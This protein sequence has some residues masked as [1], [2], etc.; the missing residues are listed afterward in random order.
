MLV[1]DV[2]AELR[3]CPELVAADPALSPQL[4]RPP[5]GYLVPVL[6]AD[7]IQERLFGETHE[8]HSVVPRTE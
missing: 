8:L 6:V 7:M 2:L 1:A 3:I 4:F 5:A